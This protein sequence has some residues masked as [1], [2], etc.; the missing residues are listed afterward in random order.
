MATSG[1]IAGSFS[2]CSAMSIRC[3]NSS[4]CP[5]SLGQ[6]FKRWKP[7]V[8]TIASSTSLVLLLS[9]S[10]MC[11]ASLLTHLADMFSDCTFQRNTWW[12]LSRLLSAFAK[13]CL[14]KRSRFF[15][16]TMTK[17]SPIWRMLM[18]SA[19]PRWPLS[20]GFVKR[21]LCSTPVH[22]I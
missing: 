11:C 3:S 15:A 1:S 8:P 17:P 19:T 13:S 20:R 22:L 21:C 6:W 10:T 18:T 12:L 5:M 9:I 16:L 14:F 2:L 4:T 7:Q